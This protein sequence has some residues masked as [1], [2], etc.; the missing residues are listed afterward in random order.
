MKSNISVSIY[1]NLD[2]YCLDKIK[3][4]KNEAHVWVIKW[5]S[6][7]DLIEKEKNCISN[8]E[9]KDIQLLRKY[10]DKMR[11]L[12]GKVVVRILIEHYLK[13]KKEK[14]L[15]E[16]TIYG[17]PYIVSNSKENLNYNISHSGEYIVLA[18]TFKKHI[19]IDVE[20][21][22]YLP[23]YKEIASYFS[24]GERDR[25]RKSKNNKL[26]FRLWTAKEA[27]IKAEGLG[28]QVPLN[29]FEIKDLKIY[30]ERTLSK[31]WEVFYTKAGENYPITMVISKH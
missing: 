13:I 7:K 24:V 28:L 14:I 25:I 29:S 19:G 11:G 2:L 5:K 27:Y 26:F 21:E 12:T 31:D 15:I 16:K 23:E 17:K 8:S 10:E 30:K 22:K 9:A 1:K 3:L 4:K 18:F 20:E 6:I